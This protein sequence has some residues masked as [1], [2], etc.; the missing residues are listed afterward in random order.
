MYKEKLN[1]ILIV[2]PILIV[3]IFFENDLFL[4]RYPIQ[5]L[6]WNDLQLFGLYNWFISVVQEGDIKDFFGSY[7]N[8]MLG[9]GHN[10][11]TTKNPNVYFD[12]GAWLTLFLPIELALEI[13]YYIFGMIFTYG[14]Y[15]LLKIRSNYFPNSIVYIILCILGLTAPIFRY[16]VGL[17]NQYFLLA[18]PMVAYL[19]AKIIDNEG[20]L[21]GNYLRLTLLSIIS[22]GVSDVHWIIYMF[23]I[24]FYLFAVRIYRGSN[25]FPYFAIALLIT[26]MWLINYAPI[27]FH[28]IFLNDTL[29]SKGG[30]TLNQWLN[31]FGVRMFSPWNYFRG[32]F[33]G[34]VS[35][36]L[37]PY[38][39]FFILL[40]VL[41]ID[42]TNNNKRHLLG[43]AY[44]CIALV[45]S[46][47]FIYS[48]EFIGQML[49]SLL[50]YHMT[51]VP[52]I[53][54]IC[55]ASMNYDF[56][57]GRK[58]LLSIMIVIIVQLIFMPRL[59]YISA[60]L[61]FC[62]T[63]SAFLFVKKIEAHNSHS[64]FKIIAMVLIGLLAVMNIHYSKNF[65]KKASFI[66]GEGHFIDYS[67]RS[68]LTKDV[69]HC[70]TD[71][72]V[73]NSIHKSTGI[74]F[75]S[76]SVSQEELRARND[77][78]MFLVEN[79]YGLNTR[80]FNQ[81]RY[82]LSAADIEY[83]SK[84]NLTGLFNFSFNVEHIDRVLSFAND[85]GA[86]NLIA[87]TI[88]SRHDLKLLGV[89]ESHISTSSAN[90]LADEFYE[91]IYVYEVLD[92]LVAQNIYEITPHKLQISC[93]KS[94]NIDQKIVDYRGNLRGL[95]SSHQCDNSDGLSRVEISSFSP[96][97][98][99]SRFLQFLILSVCILGLNWL[100]IRNRYISNQ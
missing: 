85:V 15:K 69:P 75:A 88:I 34:P 20:P 4:A 45:T 40:G 57:D 32:D 28:E 72:L 48:I 53:F 94:S 33:I 19:M 87:N 59:E 50:R 5:D 38:I 100:W 10:V 46:G 55:A 18:S 25:L 64:I 92:N 74:V 90:R 1:N 91:N 86:S 68:V 99:A 78:H 62:L 2:L 36:Y 93:A 41:S 17:L 79:P 16:E 44:T 11:L 9:M 54:M 95:V 27:L 61:L 21:L 49:P 24:L 43:L 22:I 6:Y 65:T 81:W 3:F 71:K 56:S 58:I 52:F 29:S 73:S 23:V 76:T 51:I 67:A 77:L 12:I 80:T 8:Y 82:S 63:L 84:N 31:I 7:I 70:V 37:S 13:R 97:Y 14:I 39:I 60:I 42:Q 26:S 30:W 98:F 66:L 89:C 96:F 83:A 47:V 35:I